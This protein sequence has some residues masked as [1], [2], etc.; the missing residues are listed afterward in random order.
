MPQMIAAAIGIAQRDNVVYWKTKRKINEY[1]PLT[2]EIIIHHTAAAAAA[3]AATTGT[4]AIAVALTAADVLLAGQQISGLIAA[5]GSHVSA[6]LPTAVVMSR[7]V[8]I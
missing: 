7:K 2:A 1:R 8:W 4:V 5:G 6:F 3:A